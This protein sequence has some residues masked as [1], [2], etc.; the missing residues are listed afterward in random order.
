LYISPVKKSERDQRLRSGF[1]S[2]KKR[3]VCFFIGVFFRRAL[4][5]F[6]P[7]QQ[8]AG[9]GQKAAAAVIIKSS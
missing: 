1:G 2:R 6:D 5:E 8:A 7:S 4:S 3:V 9:F